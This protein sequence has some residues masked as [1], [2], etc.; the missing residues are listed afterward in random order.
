MR[1]RA[2]SELG[3]LLE[4]E[5]AAALRADLGA[6]EALVPRKRAL[7]AALAKE[8][9]DD[10]ELE[11]LGAQFQHNLGLMN[12][13][14]LSLKHIWADVAQQAHP[15]YTARGYAVSQAPS[16]ALLPRGDHGAL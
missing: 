1:S 3:E 12:Q 7:V 8:G 5:H 14:A 13:L 16:H 2:A 15:T 4:Q 11:A 9:A 6:L 10:H